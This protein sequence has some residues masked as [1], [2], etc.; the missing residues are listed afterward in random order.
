MPVFEAELVVPC[1]PSQAFEFLVHPVNVLLVSP[2]EYKLK[3]LDAPERLFL[4]ARF[5][6]QTSKFG[7]SQKIT[8][9]VIAFDEGVGFTDAQVSGPFAKFEHTHRVEP[10]EAG[11]LL[12]DRI[13]FA[14]PGGLMG[15][16]LTNDRILRHVQSLNEYRATR[17]QELLG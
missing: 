16:L 9:A 3:I 2:P 11:T 1:S 17:F 12:R 13:E 10:H 5:T 14:G 7:I 6:I 15:L 8:S 4:G